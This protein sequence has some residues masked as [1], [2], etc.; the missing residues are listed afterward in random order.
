MKKLFLLTVYLF[1]EFQN[2]AQVD[3]AA[4]GFFSDVSGKPIYLSTEYHT[5]GS[6]YFTESFYEAHFYVKGKKFS[7]IK[8]QMDLLHNR[9]LYKIKGDFLMEPT[10]KIDSIIFTDSE[11]GPVEITFKSGYPSI[12]KQNEQSYYQTLVKGKFELLKHYTITVSDKK[13]YSSASVIRVFHKS[14]SYY[15]YNQITHQISRASFDEAT[16][17]SL[18][19]ANAAQVMKEIKNKGWRI[20]KETDLI[21]LLTYLN[22]QY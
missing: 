18:I 9:V 14:V 19:G 20:K 15:F 3:V 7:G 10:V 1:I 5:E 12:D 6:P 13:E 11:T 16:L 8:A 21:S 22:Q 4:T 17:T 2:F